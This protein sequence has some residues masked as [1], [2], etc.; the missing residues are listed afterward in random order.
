MIKNIL[1]LLS[2]AKKEKIK[3]DYID[4]ALGKNKLPESIK[5]GYEMLKQELWLKKK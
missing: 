4:I 2:V 1:E 5:E 3:G